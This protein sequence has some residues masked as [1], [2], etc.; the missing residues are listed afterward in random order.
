MATVLDWNPTV[1]PAE[2]VRE[3]GEALGA[4]SLVVLPGDAG[5][6]V[7]ASAST[8]GGGLTALSALAPEPPAVLASG[9]DVIT[10]PRPK[11]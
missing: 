3:L 8:A 5:Y 2:L 6:V 11:N 1:D 10:L 4:G 7:L 9:P